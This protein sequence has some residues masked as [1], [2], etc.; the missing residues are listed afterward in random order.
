MPARHE[1]LLGRTTSLAPL[2]A[3]H[4]G[5]TSR[6]AAATG[7]FVTRGS[8][9]SAT[10]GMLARIPFHPID[11][12]KAR[13]Q[14]QSSAAAAS[15]T[16]SSGGAAYRNAFAGLV[17]VARAEGLRGLYRGFQMAFVGSA[18]AACLY[19]TSY[20]WSREKLT[21]SS[22]SLAKHESVVHFCAG[23]AAEAVSCVL[24]VP[25]DVIKER[26][27]IQPFAKG[28][29]AEAAAAA[30]KRGVAPP[31]VY[32]RGPIHAIRYTLQNEG[33]FGLYRVRPCCDCLPADRLVCRAPHASAP[34][35]DTGP[36]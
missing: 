19:F 9:G 18:P 23:M 33:L 2:H 27:Q 21:A 17:Q 36:R 3:F 35:R 34:C 11:T 6:A 4:T 7:T 5:L 8:Q 14:V 20:E 28:G 10:A 16:A 32:Y 12:I 29:E 24:W 26:M 15:A 13:L 22:T 30:A 31:R 25:I 1:A